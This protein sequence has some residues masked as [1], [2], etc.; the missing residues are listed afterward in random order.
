[1]RPARLATALDLKEVE[2]LK[3]MGVTV[4]ALDITD[5]SS[6]VEVVTSVSKATGGMLDF[7][8]NNAG[9]GELHRFTWK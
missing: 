8:V 1:M 5:S 4:L 9:I 6:I 7:L 3:A 2:R